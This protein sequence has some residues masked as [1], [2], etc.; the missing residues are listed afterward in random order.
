MTRGCKVI[1]DDRFQG[2][3]ENPREANQ[4]ISENVR[5]QPSGPVQPRPEYAFSVERRCELT[6]NFL[7][8]ERNQVWVS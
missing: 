1:A 3:P 8:P 7:T 2:K 4:V 5:Q 6:S